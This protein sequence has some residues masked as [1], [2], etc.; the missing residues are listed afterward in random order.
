[1]ITKVLVWV[2][3]ANTAAVLSEMLCKSLWEKHQSCNQAKGEISIQIV[4][5]GRTSSSSSVSSS[6][7]AK[8]GLSGDTACEPPL[9]P[10][11]LKPGPRAEAP[12]LLCCSNKAGS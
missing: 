10:C 11:T 7:A 2:R 4:F 6:S 3:P 1:M 8:A 5:A 12:V 9:A